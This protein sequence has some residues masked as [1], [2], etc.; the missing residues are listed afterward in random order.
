M[1]SMLLKGIKLQF[2]IA[3]VFCLNSCSP[4][5]IANKNLEIPASSINKVP[6]SVGLLLSSDICN[7]KIT[8]KYFGGIDYHFGEAICS[9]SERM[10][11]NFFSKVVVL[12]TKDLA[13]IQGLN[14]VIVLEIVKGNVLQPGTKFQKFEALIVIKY[15]VFDNN[16]NILWQ[17]SFQGEGAVRLGFY[18]WEDVRKCLTISLEDH[19]RKATNGMLLSKWWEAIK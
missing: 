11:N 18:D 5:F 6:I 7:Y 2:I 12:K 14:A 4:K 8:K 16:K 10:L 17:D 13:S 9:G 15:T 3:I 1:T 19:F